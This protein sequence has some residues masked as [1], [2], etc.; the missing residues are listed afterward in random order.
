[1]VLAPTSARTGYGSF[2]PTA[3]DHGAQT[4]NVKA[5]APLVGSMSLGD[6]EES[7]AELENPVDDLPPRDR[8]HGELAFKR[9]LA[10][11]TIRGN[12]FANGNSQGR[13][14]EVL[15]RPLSLRACRRITLGAREP[16][17]SSF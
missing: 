2:S 8:V 9:R 17:C 1:M 10:V 5:K 12:G 14:A 13:L 15:G 7:L 6:V 16:R 11:Q 3:P 4:A